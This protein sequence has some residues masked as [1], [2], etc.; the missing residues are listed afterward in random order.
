MKQIDRILAT[1]LV[2]S[3]FS[4]YFGGSTSPYPILAGPVIIVWAIIFAR[5]KYLGR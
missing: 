4:W 3:V 1:M 5:R 2:G